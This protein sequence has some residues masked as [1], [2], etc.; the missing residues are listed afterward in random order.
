[1]GSPNTKM[2]YRILLASFALILSAGML[3]PPAPAANNVGERK[4]HRL[5]TLGLDVQDP[6]IVQAAANAH[7]LRSVDVFPKGDNINVVLQLSGMPSY[8]SYIYPDKR[9]MV[10]DLYNTINIA[11][12]SEFALSSG[13]PIHVVRNA[14]YS[15]D[16]SIIARVVLELDAEVTPE[17]TIDGSNLVITTPMVA[18]TE[19][20]PAI[21][22]SV[23]TLQPVVKSPE[24]AE[25]AEEPVE[26]A[27]VEDAHEQHGDTP[28]EVIAVPGVEVETETPEVEIVL[29]SA[30]PDAKLAD[31]MSWAPKETEWT[32][33]PL[34]IEEAQEF[35]EV[36]RPVVEPEPAAVEVEVEEVN[37]IEKLIE[38]IAQ[39]P[40]AEEPVVVAEELAPVVE[41]EQE[42]AQEALGAE[43]EEAVEVVMADLE[44]AREA[45]P[46]VFEPE[47]PAQ[48]SIVIETVELEIEPEAAPVEY[49]PVEDT[50]VEVMDIVEAAPAEDTRVEVMDI[51][52][53]APVEDTRVEVMDIVEVAPVEDTRVEAVAEEIPEAIETEDA[54]L[55]LESVEEIEVEDTGVT[56]ID[57]AAKELNG[58]FEEMAEQMEGAMTAEIE[59]AGDPELIAEEA[60][61]AFGEMFSEMAEVMTSEMSE[62][63]TA[64]MTEVEVVAYEP[65]QDDVEISRAASLEETLVTLEFRDAELSAVLDILAR[66]GN[67][68]IIAGKGVKGKVT[69][70]LVEVPLDVALNA[71][72]NVNGFGY[73][74][75]D[76]IVRILPLSEI[77]DVV[78]LVTK[79]YNLS[80]AQAKDAKKTLDSFLTPNGNIEVDSRTNMLLV[81]DIPG[82]TDRLEKLI[83]EIDRR[84][85]QV[86]IEVIILDSVLLDDA[87]LGVSWGLLNTSDNSP[88]SKEAVRLGEE[89]PFP[90]Q[91][92]IN[93][94]TGADALNVVF[95]TLFGDLSLDI[96]IDA[97][98][99]DTDTKVLANPKILTLNNETAIIE[100]I[101]E[102]PYNDVTQTSSGGQLSNITF[103][104]IG[105]K[106]EVR[107]QITHDDHVILWV[108]PEQ[109]SIA[110]FTAIGVP[111][112]DT[113]RA[114]TTLILKNHQTIVMGGLRENRD[115]NTLNKV[116]FFG[117]LPGVKYAFR[118]V[119]SAKRDTELLVFITVHIMESPALLPEEKM[120]AEELANLPRHPNSTV[121]LIR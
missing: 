65:P 39:E 35:E 102:H 59:D 18:G 23:E 31:E 92:N 37:H 11:P 121:E 67:L 8:N 7:A 41:A 44:Q 91:I 75:T 1:M 106:L 74:K 4:L 46:D 17:I 29:A 64:E 24:A 6:T 76:N 116:P 45:A 34:E 88:N 87:D 51:V 21:E 69:V 62:M 107:P 50:R 95:G 85:Q 84:V 81:T 33:T 72:L 20:A 12:S 82:N 2:R 115:V 60:L 26:Y 42:T 22:L 93:L 101:T 32:E 97:M 36:A 14:Q 109:N 43:A 114:E 90:D 15:V 58:M 53:A 55:E 54:P 73:L 19:R 98:V 28:A 71:I 40:V 119:Q 100:I 63:M 68:N 113:R 16:P 99:S 79:T 80:Y 103:K 66:K 48:E 61:K 52:E 104:E 96:F 110:G 118:S 3:S 108:A 9:R 13:D 57:E 70:R 111:I 117:D 83:K 10:L 56:D 49:A 38:E 105:T 30:V 47:A 86:L 5:A 120:K 94:P 78:N 25:V 27:Y 89:D 77:G 112:V